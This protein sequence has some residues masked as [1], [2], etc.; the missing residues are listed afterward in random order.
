MI[1]VSDPQILHLPQM[2]NVPAQ[3]DT[4]RVVLYVF[5]VMLVAVLAMGWALVTA[6]HAH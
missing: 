3:S 4:L 2:W 5:N 1:F 6:I